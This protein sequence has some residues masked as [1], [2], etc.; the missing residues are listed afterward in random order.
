MFG[1]CSGYGQKP[2]TRLTFRTPSDTDPR[3]F[4]G[5][6]LAQPYPAWYVFVPG[7]ELSAFPPGEWYES[8]SIYNRSIP[9]P[10]STPREGLCRKIGLVVVINQ[11]MPLGLGIGSGQGLL[12]SG[13]RQRL[14]R[15]HHV[16]LIDEPKVRVC[17]RCPG[18]PPGRRPLG[19][20][21]GR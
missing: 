13:T 17:P 5:S 21:L 7:D 3:I 15:N 14:E 10:T 12:A 16:D 1:V 19:E 20:H 2:I 18:C 4:Q 9:R 8:H 6:F 11:L